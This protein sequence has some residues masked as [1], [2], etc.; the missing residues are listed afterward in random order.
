MDSPIKFLKLEDK[1]LPEHFIRVVQ[2]ERRLVKM[3]LS[4]NDPSL[5]YIV[6]H[7]IL[8]ENTTFEPMSRDAPGGVTRIITTK[9]LFNNPAYRRTIFRG[10]DYGIRPSPWERFLETEEQAPKETLEQAKDKTPDSDENEI[11]DPS[12]NEIP[13]EVE[14]KSEDQTEDEIDD[15]T[16]D[17]TEDQ[18]EDQSIWEKV[19]AAPH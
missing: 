3:R 1:G 11:A 8:P 17:E 6:L 5:N 16:K 19:H 2:S 13:D 15:E 7:G 18:T 9:E 14:D 10:K 4:W 12:E